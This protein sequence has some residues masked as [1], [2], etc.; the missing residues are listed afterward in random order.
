MK[1]TTKGLLLGLCMTLTLS[2]SPVFSASAAPQAQPKAKYSEAQVLDYGKWAPRNYEVVQNLINENGVKSKSYNPGKKPYAVFDWDNTSIM[3][4]TEEALLVYQM[5]NLMF[6]MTPE[7]FEKAIRTNVPAGPF[8]DDFKTVDGK[9]VIFDDVVADVVSD[10]TYIYNHYK[11]LKG[12][13]SLETVTNTDQF[14]DFRAKMFFMYEA[15]NGT[16]G[17]AVGY[18]WVLYLF[19]NMTVDEVQ[20]MAEKSDD[21]ALGN[22]IHTLTWTSPESMKGK[23]G[24]VTVEH[25]T[26]IRMTTEI[27]NLMNTLRSNGIDVYVVSASLEEVVEV[28][29]SNPKY[30]YSLPKENVIGMRLAMDAEGKFMPKA[31]DNWFLTVSHGKT[32][33][34]K[35]QIAKTHG[36]AGPLLIGGD[37]K[38]DYE[39][40]TEFPDTKLRLIVNRV[41]GGTI[42]KASTLAA[43][44]MK[45]PQPQFILQGR[46]ENTGEWRPSEET[47]KLGK[48]E[49]Q[50]LKK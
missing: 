15:I 29:A 11:G 21:Y 48:T 49:P 3:N 1:K 45:Q 27:R 12:S 13:E 40:M 10:Y 14:Q 44:Q 6:K 39:M 41:S 19:D 25:V 8:S 35:D 31:K 36:G 2:M 46:D 26:G 43:E 28:F 50:L 5:N 32:E 42:G 4:D 33:V 17:N 34:I 24:V 38:G 9:K 23:A 20:K 37:S 7:E 16:H 22:A 47:I 18:H 30:G